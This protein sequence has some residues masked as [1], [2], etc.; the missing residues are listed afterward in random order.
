MNE[1][2]PRPTKDISHWHTQRINDVEEAEYSYAEEPQSSQ[3][4]DYWNVLVK[5]RRLVIL[6]FLAVFSIVAYINFSATPLYTASAM[7]QIEPQNPAVTG[8]AEILS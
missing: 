6:V 8:L 1:I 7:L 5:R 3:I 2:T 4:R